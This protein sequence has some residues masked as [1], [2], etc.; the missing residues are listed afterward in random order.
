LPIAFIC[1]YLVLITDFNMADKI[2]AGKFPLVPS[3]LFCLSEYFYFKSW[4]NVW[5]LNVSLNI[6]CII[7]HWMYHWI[8]NVSLNIE[9]IIE[10]WMN[11][12][13]LNVCLNIECVIEYWIVHVSVHILRTRCNKY[14]T[15]L[16]FGRLILATFSTF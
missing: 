4:M 1:V 7:E 9:C 5:I 15:L 16:L 13:T 8:L 12:W 2:L 10:Y 14:L 6:E 3:T 11:V